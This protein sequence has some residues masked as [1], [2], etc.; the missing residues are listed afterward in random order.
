MLYSAYEKSQDST[1]I[2]YQG[3]E[4]EGEFLLSQSDTAAAQHY[5]HLQVVLGLHLHVDGIVSQL[6]SNSFTSVLHAYTLSVVVILI[7]YTLVAFSA[8]LEM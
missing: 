8:Y 7:I 5:R 3:G 2:C 1:N 4:G 6:N